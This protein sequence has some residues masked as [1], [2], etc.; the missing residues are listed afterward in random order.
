MEHLENLFRDD[1]EVYDAIEAD[2]F[3]IIDFH[4]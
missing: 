4:R 3:D 1:R 2:I